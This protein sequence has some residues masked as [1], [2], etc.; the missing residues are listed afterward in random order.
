MVYCFTNWRINMFRF[1]EEILHNRRSQKLFKRTNELCTKHATIA[2]IYLTPEAREEYANL[3]REVEANFHYAM[4][5]RFKHRHATMCCNQLLMFI[6][7]AKAL[8][9][10][11]SKHKTPKI[12]TFLETVSSNYI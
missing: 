6:T 7:I 8:T 5:N 4:K 9:P 2:Y 12:P 1:I 11:G 10:E 3:V